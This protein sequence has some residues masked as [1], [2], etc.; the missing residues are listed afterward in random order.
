MDLNPPSFEGL[1]GAELVQ[2]GLAELDS[3]RV[4]IYAL[5][6]AAATT[7]LRELGVPVPLSA[8][9]IEEPEMSLYSELCKSMTGPGDDPY[10]RYNSLRR[11][12]DSFISTLGQLRHRR[13]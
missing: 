12:L 13:A 4:G 7:R 1:P 10:Y 9:D 11:E 6:L 3:G 5:L 2:Q 8:K